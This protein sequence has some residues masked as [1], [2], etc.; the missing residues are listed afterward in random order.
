MNALPSRDRHPPQDLDQ[1][2]APA[3]ANLANRSVA[4]IMSQPVVALTPDRVLDEA[5]HALVRFGI[6]HLAVVHRGGRCL[7]IISDRMIVSAWAHNMS[8]LGVRRVRDLLEPEPAT[9][10]PQTT[11]AEV[12]RVMAQLRVDAVAVTEPDGTLTGIVTGS[13]LVALLSRDD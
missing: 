13:D 11:V 7:G 12:A 5:L 9:V 10:H 2:A 8:C 6:R 1:N 3:P 4:E